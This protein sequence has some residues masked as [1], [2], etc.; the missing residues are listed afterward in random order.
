MTKEP[1]DPAFEISFSVG[2]TGNTIAYNEESPRRRVTDGN[3]LAA[4]ATAVPDAVGEQSNAVRIDSSGYRVRMV[5]GTERRLLPAAAVEATLTPLGGDGR[6][7]T[8]D[9]SPS[10]RKDT[11]PE[12]N[13]DGKITTDDAAITAKTP[14]TPYY[15][16][17]SNNVVD[18]NGKSVYIRTGPGVSSPSSD[19][20]V[21]TRAKYNPNVP[22]VNPVPVGYRF[23]YNEESIN[24][25]VNPAANISI[26]VKGTNVYPPSVATTGGP[27]PA[28]V[29][30]TGTPTLTEQ[31][32][33]L[34]S[35][36]TLLFD[37]QTPGTYTVKI[38]DSTPDHDF[39]R[40][41]VPLDLGTTTGT[42]PRRAEMEF[43][44]YVTEARNTTIYTIGA[45]RP[46]GTGTTPYLRVDTGKDLEQINDDF[47]VTKGA[48]G[49]T[50]LESTDNPE[51][52]YKVISGNGTLYAA[53][54]S[55]ADP[56]RGPNQDLT[57]HHLALVFLNTNGTTN[58]VSVSV[59]GRDRQTHPATIVYE[60][61]GD[62]PAR[63]PNTNPNPNPNPTPR[64]PTTVTVS[65]TTISGAPGSTRT[66]TITGPTTAQLTIGS[67]NFSVA[68]GAVSPSSGTGSLTST[69]TLPST[70]GAY[71]LT[72]NDAGTPVQTVRVNVTT[73]TTGT[74]PTTGTLSISV[75]FSGAPGSTQTAT[76]TATG[77]GGTAA[78]GV[79]ITLAVTNGG[80]TFNPARV[81]TGPD[82]TAVSVLTRG[83]AVGTNYFATANAT[84]YTEARTRI[85]IA[86]GSTPPTTGTTPP[87]T[88]TTPTVSGSASSIRINGQATRTGTVNQQL[89]APLVIEVLDSNGRSVGDVRV[90]FRVR[91]GQGTAFA[92]REWT[93]DRS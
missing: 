85:S 66:L 3:T 53:A 51:L 20:Y 26:R 82:G 79:T 91:T 7:I 33:I 17:T 57:V 52:R 1:N 56:Y 61:S 41:A 72:V 65:P 48:D 35:S 84:R 37:T 60:Y 14:T 4:I 74:T 10:L 46:T 44:L 71:S 75:P 30:W 13:L 28:A 49:T 42:R 80:G 25:A 92:A 32:G 73:T 67:L 31:S 40:N 5:A 19:P 76:I 11:Y 89:A 23:D 88:G 55:Q 43:T 83:S 81:T 70:V 2:L 24:V 59:A 38:A 87:T 78:S 29:T 68:G 39:P 64:T 9:S 18:S 86:T 45:L 27:P 54:D 50:D 93:C 15:V 12:G 21:Y 62:S 90:I 16:D 8:V 6:V 63:S 22:N 47:K 58:E 69:L 36:M 34:K 77:S